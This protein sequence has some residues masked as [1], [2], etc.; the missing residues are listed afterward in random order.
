MPTLPGAIRHPCYLCF[1][2]FLSYMKNILLFLTTLLSLTLSSQTPGRYADVKISLIGKTMAELVQTGIE[3]EHGT[4]FPGRSIT[5]VLS[6]S[7]I[8]KVQQAG[9]KTE[10][11]IPDLYQDYLERCAKPQAVSARGIDCNTAQPPF[12]DYVTPANYSY[13]SM[14]GYLT[15]N[16]M[17]AE[18][19]KMRSL[20]PNLISVRKVT[21]DTILTWDN[22][23]IYQVKISDNPDVDEPERKVLY[24]ALHHAREPNSASQL[25]F[26]MWYLLENYATRPDIQAI[27]NN[28][29]LYFVPCINVDGYKYNELNSPNG[30]GFWRKNRR[31]NGDGTFGI[32][33]NRNYGY[34]WGDFGGSSP[35]PGSEIYRG[36]AAF[37]EPESRTM[38]DFCR[39]HD[40]LFVLNYHTHG[41]LLIYP[42]AYSD[43]PAD[44]A[45]IKYGRHF[46][47]ENHYHYG[48]TTETV[49]YSVNGSSDD[50]MYGETG[51]YSFTPEVGTTGFWPTP[52]E[53]DGL[54]K[55]NLWQNFTM[56][57]SALRY[58]ASKDLSG[59]KLYGK[60]GDIDIE[61]M[62]YGL[63]DGPINVTLQ[64]F[65]SNISSVTQ[66]KS[67]DIAH[68]E[69]STHSFPYQ[70]DANTQTGDPLV[71][72]LKTDN[73]LWV[74]TDTLRKNYGGNFVISAGTAFQDNLD[75]LVN[76]Q[77][78][79][80]I[81][82]ETFHSPSTC[83]TD[84]PNA[85]YLPDTYVASSLQSN[86]PI[87]ANAISA[88]LRFFAKW[89][90]ESSWDYVQ[91]VGTD[92]NNFSTPL[93]GLYTKPG[94]NTQDEG[95][96]FD[97]VQG[98]WVEECMDVSAFIGQTPV[99]SF[100]LVSDGVTEGDGFYFD[101]IQIEYTLATSGT[102]TIDVS[103]FLL[104]Q[105]EPNPSSGK[106]FIQWE[107]PSNTLGSTANL[108]VFNFLGE[109]VLERNVDLIGQKSISL[110]TRQLN[111]GIYSYFLRSENGQSK[112]LKMSV[113]R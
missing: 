19:D 41:N 111:P 68:L 35:D 22:N 80:A 74:K 105:N 56:A 73:G 71:F 21:S 85:D 30:G 13:G 75:N 7:E 59:A 66:S 48:T 79:W 58:G 97:G 88:N 62:R 82:N 2:S 69:K 26:Y 107:S 94:V 6:E 100:V 37:S 45:F 83:M 106:T 76:W 32:D 53:I 67:F 20:Y 36:P 23:V 18:L 50:W 10:I 14:G 24:T 42:W 57:Y 43:S 86:T 102:H 16:Q 70:L 89:D 29:E 72:L 52:G 61:F 60:N 104:K 33:L 4:Y 99:I 65:S 103:S 31:D 12:P 15:Y 39:E 95:P 96:I 101:D 44:P 108:M 40:F 51:A 113:L 110:D 55:E 3:T 47:E 46:S 78:D 9:F 92:Q 27:V 8:S 98:E 25:I 11:L 87:P 77:G 5:T 1:K 64:P 34:F 90:I 63:L 91:V 17:M 84:S 28:L 81:T 109:L 38:R 93:C 112:T 54:N 49:G